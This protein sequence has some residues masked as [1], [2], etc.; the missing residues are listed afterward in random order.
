[1]FDV[2]IIGSGV[3]GSIVAR[4]LSRYKLNI[5]VI[6]ADSDVANGTS[7]ANSAIVHAGFDAKPDTLK[8]KLNAKGNKMFD[9]LSEELDFPFKRIGSLVL[10]FDEN[11]MDN[12][13]KLKEQ[14][15]KNGV[16]NLEILSGDKVRELEPNLS[17][18][19]VAALYA[20]TGAI[21]CPY[22]MTIAL[23]E[24]AADNGVEFK[25]DTKVL[26]V[27]KDNDT[28]TIKTDKG[29][30]ESKL[31][32]NA[33]GVFADE[34]NN[35]VSSNKMHIIPRKGQY[36]LFDKAVG[37]TVSRTI[38]QLPTKMGKGVLVTPTVDGNLLI[39]PNAEDIGDKEDLATTSTG[40]DF[41]IEK[42]GLSINQVPMRQLITSFSGLRAHSVEGDFIIGE[43]EDAKGFINAAGIESPGLSSA[44]SIAELI[45]DI[46][47]ERLNPNKN[48]KFN[49]IRKGIP[50]FREMTNE[51]R[52]KLISEDDRYGKIICRCETVTEGEI[53]NSINRTLGA[54]SLDGVKKRTRAGMGRCQS[55]FC[56]PKVVEILARELHISPEDVT[57]FGKHSNILVG[58]DKANI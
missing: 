53:V 25:L 38:F 3:I 10:C 42:A 37:N 58:K 54:R 17:K 44:P 36:C 5:C 32:I 24:N 11:D 48:D 19:V 45:K 56:A 1:M 15:E 21:V 16:P 40:M 12:L 57:K 41:I 51:D 13:R 52:K 29:F 18:K 34:I 46:V 31:V 33:A 23:A 6:E 35:M 28:Y 50:K 14:G 2:T 20:P 22:E 49:P 4:E 47:V 39:G 7:K 9:R 43:A 26:D 55:G 27:K 30:V 8:G